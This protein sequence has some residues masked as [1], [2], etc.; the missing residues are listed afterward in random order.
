MPGINAV[1]RTVDSPGTLAEPCRSIRRKMLHLPHYTEKT[2]VS[3]GFLDIGFTGYRNYP[4]RIIDDTA[5]CAVVEGMMYDRDEAAVESGMREMAEA[6]IRAEGAP[7]ETICRMLSDADGEFVI[8]IYDKSGRRVMIVNDVMGRL[9]LYYFSADGMLAVSREL[10]FIIPFLPSLVFNPMAAMEYL[11]YGFPFEEHT[12]IDRVH[13]IPGATAFHFDA[14]SGAFSRICYHEMNLERLPEMKGNRPEIVAE[15]KRSFLDALRN[16]ADR[17]KGRK[18]LVSLSGGLDSRGTMAGLKV[19]GGDPVAVTAQGTEE[20]AA[21]EAAG[22]VGVDVYPLT[23]GE[24]CGSLNFEDI[25]FLKD[26]LDCH[27]DLAQLYYNLQEM[28]NHFG[29]DMVYYTGIFGGE[30]TRHNHVTGGLAGMNSLVRY[31]LKAHDRCKFST[32]KVAQLFCVPAETLARRLHE[33]LNGFPEK[34]VYK[35]YLRFK[36]E[37]DMRFAGEAE[38]RNRYFFWT[39]SPYLAPSFFRCVMSQNEN[40]KNSRLFRDFLFSI[41][42]N[43]CKAPYHNFRLPLDNQFL[44]TLFSMC[45]RMLRNAAVKNGVRALM[46]IVEGARG[47]IARR[48]GVESAR[49]RELRTDI[50]R[51]TEGSEVIRSFFNNPDLV[52]LVAGEGDLQGL[53]RL[54]IILVYLD[55]AT[56]W[57]NVLHQTDLFLADDLRPLRQEALIPQTSSGLSIH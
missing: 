18:I 5:Y 21:R 45:E 37:A 41:D 28:L 44:L 46:R 50:L 8:V 36:H 42:P 20:S 12:L 56:R 17:T 23:Q 55:R 27:P 24:S 39:I 43:T 1:V 33:R 48:K 31:L 51:M 54:R 4:I 10:K 19:L 7:I 13:F 35:K 30:I 34:S 29:E 25:V 52:S 53:E 40:R 22:A 14:N 16:R 47:L 26:G 2:V 15:M 49:V 57:Y 38:D 3:T 9:P 32:E 11:Q 6:F